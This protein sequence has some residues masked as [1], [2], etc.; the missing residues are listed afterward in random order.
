MLALDEA[1]VILFVC[2]VELG[3]TDLDQSFAKLLRKV[4]KPIYLVVNKVDNGERLYDA[5]EFYKLGIGEELFPILF[6]QRFRVRETCWTKWFHTFPIIP[7][8]KRNI[9]PRLRS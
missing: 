7:L 1:D 4:D 3:I 6:R 9:F 2:D 8:K 5:H